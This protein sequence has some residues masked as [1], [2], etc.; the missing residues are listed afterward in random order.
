M[1]VFRNS[2]NLLTT[3][4][5]VVC[6]IHAQATAQ[7]SQSLE[8]AE[9]K[10]ALEYSNKRIAAL[11]EQLKEQKAQANAY[12]ESLAAANAELQQTRDTHNQLRMQMEG[13]GVAAIDSSGT[14]LEQKLLTALSDL[15]VVEQQKRKL[16]EALIGL[17]E[18][19]IANA[20]GNQNDTSTK[21]NLEQRLADAE[22][23]LAYL[24][25]EPEEQNLGTLQNASIVSL[26][27]ELG[28]AVLNVGS[29]Q[30]V[31]PGMPFSIYRQ[32]KPI[33]RALI[34]DVR[35]AVSGA[36]VQELIDPN[37][38]V[39]IGDVGKVETDFKG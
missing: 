4:V 7:N 15:R 13:L 5:A 16:T 31:L 6:M 34:V 26:K 35:G 22:K 18:S 12:A 29:K 20:N 1:T 24:H 37:D 14:Q 19:V 32:D 8:L 28:I 30:G 21:Q 2:M 36:I 17:T 11:E 25:A 33:A 10:T 23:A 38:R 27:D 3:P 39:K 9:V